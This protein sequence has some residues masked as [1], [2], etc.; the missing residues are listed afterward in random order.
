VVAGI[1]E[2]AQSLQREETQ[3]F[4]DMSPEPVALTDVMGLA[5]A[6]VLKCSG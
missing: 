3:I 5:D 6:R 2:K 1:R 4:F